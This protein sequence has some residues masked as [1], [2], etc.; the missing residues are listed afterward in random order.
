MPIRIRDQGSG[1][2]IENEGF[3]I[4]DQGLAMA[5]AQIEIGLVRH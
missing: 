2:T 4:R 1:I 5:E 3:R